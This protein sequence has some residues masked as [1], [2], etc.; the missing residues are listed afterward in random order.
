MTVICNQCKVEMQ[1]VKIGVGVQQM[2]TQG[3]YSLHSGDILRCL[4]CGTDVIAGLGTPISEHF[5]PD[6]YK[7]VDGWHPVTNVWANL[8]EKNCYEAE[9]QK[10]KG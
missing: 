1:P 7:K 10:V 9:R 8:A 6:Y 5:K 4:G 3:P 2:T